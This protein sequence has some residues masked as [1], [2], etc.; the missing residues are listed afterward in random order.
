MIPQEAV[1]IVEVGPRDGLQNLKEFVETEKKISLIRRL[2]ESGLR[3]IEGGSF[4]HPKAIPQF[5]D[6]GDVIRGVL[7]LGGVKL[8]AL[9][10]NLKG[11]RNALESGIRTL[12]FVIS[13]S[14]SHNLN[15][16]RL[17]PDESF[18]ELKKIKEM[19]SAYSGM[20]I[21]L[22]LATTFGCPFEMKVKEEDVLRFVE[23]G[24]AEGIRKITLCDTVGFANPR[25]VE[26]ITHRCL[27]TFPE[28]TFGVHFHNTR[29]LGLANALA[30]YETGIR[31]F[32]SSVGGL[33]GC[34]FAPGASGNV[35]TE[36]IVF[37]FNEMGVETGVDIQCLLKASQYLKEILPNVALTSALFNAGLPGQVG[38]LDRNPGLISDPLMVKSSMSRMAR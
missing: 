6:I 32:D 17:T 33:G 11:A 10:P 21:Q 12:I 36:D 7:D 8:T 13:V 23:R 16:V 37:M 28:I 26:Q 15:N 18:E 1:Q 19:D 14:R 31:F 29:G 38:L 20:E 9:I 5:R 4:V 22:D 27:E 24:G 2:A 3:E 30:A 34:P 25:Q 35:A